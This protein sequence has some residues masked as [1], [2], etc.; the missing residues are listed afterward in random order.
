M[1][2]APSDW[3]PL[4]PRGCPDALDQPALPSQ[5]QPRRYLKKLPLQANFYPMPVMA[6]IQDAR[7]RLTL[8][9][10]QALGVSSL[11]DGE[12]G[13]QL[14]RGW[15]TK[16]SPICAPGP[17]V[18]GP[19]PCGLHHSRLGEH[20]QHPV[21]RTGTAGRQ[22]PAVTLLV[23]A[24]MEVTWGWGPVGSFLEAPEY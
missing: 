23:E 24:A 15:R 11:H 16:Q 18:S 3:G 9:T 12:W 19:H 14:C 13:A 10:A 20:P 8:H 7:D 22:M 2:R 4:G 6:Y 21:S 1:I 17:P 5:V